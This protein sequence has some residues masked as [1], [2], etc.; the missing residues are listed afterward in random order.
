MTR[1]QNR[2]RRS[3]AP[4]PYLKPL[5]LP[6][7][8][9][10][11]TEKPAS[12]Y[13]RQQMWK[14]AEMR[15]RAQTKEFM[16][17]VRVEQRRR[18]RK[19]PRRKR[20]LRQLEALRGR[21][22]AGSVHL[23]DTA[24][25]VR[26]TEDL[27]EEIE[28]R[29]EHGAD[30]RD[31]TA[32][33]GGMT[34]SAMA[35]TPRIAGKETSKATAKKTLTA[36]GKATKKRSRKASGVKPGKVSWIHGTKLKF[37]VSR[38]DDWHTVDLQGSVALGRFL[39]KMANLYILKYGYELGDNKDLAEDVDDPVDADAKV[40]GPDD[41]TE[42]EAEARSKF[43]ATLRHRIGQWYRHIY[44]GVDERDKNLFAELLSGALDAGL[45]YPTKPQ[46]T[47][48]YSRRHYAERIK[49]HFDLEW[50]LEVQNAK[51]LGEDMPYEIAVRNKVTKQAWE[52]ETD[53]FR[54]G[55]LADLE[56]EHQAAVKAWEMA[57]AEGPEKIPE[58]LHASLKNA[59]F[60]LE[61]LA[62][63][64]RR[65]FGMNV[66]ILLCGP[67]GE[68]GGAIEVRSVHAGS[69]R[70]MAPQKWYQCD[71]RGY[72]ATEQSFIK[73]SEQCFT[74]EDCQ[75][76]VVDLTTHA[77]STTNGV[78]TAERSPAAPMTQ[79][80]AAGGSVTPHPL[81]NEADNSI[82]CPSS[83]DLPPS[84]PGDGD[85]GPP[86]R[87]TT[88]APAEH[89]VW[90]DEMNTGDR[91]AS[92]VKSWVNLEVAA[93]CEDHGRHMPADGRPREMTEFISKGRKWYDLPK[94]KELGG[95]GVAGSYVD[96]WCLWWQGLHPA[97]RELVDRELT[98]PTELTWERLPSMYGRLGF[99]LVL[100]SLQIW[101]QAEEEAGS[102]GGSATF[103]NAVANV[104]W[105][106]ET[107][108]A[109]GEVVPK[110]K[111][112]P[113]KK[114]PAATSS[115]RKRTTEGSDW[116]EEEEGRRPT[117]QAKKD[118]EAAKRQ[119]RGSAAKTVPAVARPQPRRKTCT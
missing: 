24:T 119:T 20:L 72:T 2:T 115:K 102:L 11:A 16:E 97:E 33:N 78:I 49:A 83:P 34:Y 118:A 27:E 21:E 94:I 66:A 112:C 37:F 39:T 14:D 98:R 85:S 38:S 50:A 75:S 81:R 114:T 92:L 4:T 73:F 68:R 42:E 10:I 116:E 57:N 23:S 90:S 30:W 6:P 95:V 12:F 80:V 70:G 1:A 79:Q 19:H 36:P 44:R 58:Q 26:N 91:W 53:N 93:G 82:S 52:D 48:L 47:H 74:Q 117:R 31:F 84:L 29:T 64:I 86:R 18:K 62:A 103:W 61:P 101:A 35:Q 59:V 17:A 8:D 87:E 15:A 89:E 56:V 63:V 108:L 41:L 65:K 88:P 54:E 106:L 3:R 111:S 28:L 51:D 43:H 109:S 71:S 22:D 25:S 69:T 9:A 104:H 40:P 46:A 7:D 105:L 110:E 67:V 99:M 76:H 55:V 77:A 13:D 96:R 45:P 60:L 100:L 32:D 5:P 113:A 107:M